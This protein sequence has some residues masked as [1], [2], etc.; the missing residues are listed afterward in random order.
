MLFNAYHQVGPMPWSHVFLSSIWLLWKDR[1][2]CIFNHKNPNLNLGKNIVDHAS[3][4][5]FCVNNGLVPKRTILKSIRW[6][7]PRAGWLTLNTDGSATSIFGPASGGGLI[8]DE[9]RGWV[10]GFARR[11]GNTNSFMAE[12]WAL[13]DGLQLC[14]QMSVHSVTI[15]LDAKIIVDAFNSPTSWNSIVYSIMEDCRQMANRIPLVCFRHIYKEANK[16]ADFLA[17]LGMLLDRDFIVFSSPPVDL[18]SLMEADAT[19]LYVN[20]L[21]HEPLFAV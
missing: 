2:S 13:R 19:G 1:N 7:K 4:L 11:I 9:N 8:R 12:L 18:A 10:T 20:R 15:E 5:F 16:C 17:R 21:C 3:E 6:E 14:L